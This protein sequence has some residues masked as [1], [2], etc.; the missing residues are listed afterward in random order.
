MKKVV[1]VVLILLLITLIFSFIVINN[2]NTSNK[3]ISNEIIRLK[4]SNETIK[5][6]SL[7]YEKE[8]NDLKEGNKDKCEELEVW[9]K[10]KQKIEKVLN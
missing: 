9:Q 5:K 10:T 1:I 6:E 8:I 7:N 4:N 3:N 2:L